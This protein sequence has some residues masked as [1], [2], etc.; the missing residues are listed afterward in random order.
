MKSIPVIIKVLA[1]FF[2]KS[3]GSRE[4]ILPFLIPLIIVS[5][6]VGIVAAIVVAMCK[7]NEKDLV[8]KLKTQ[9]NITQHNKINLWLYIYLTVYGMFLVLVLLA[10]VSG[11][12]GEMQ[13][14]TP[15]GNTAN[16]NYDYETEMQEENSA[17]GA[18]DIILMAVIFGILI[19][20]IIAI[21]NFT[22][23]LWQVIPSDIARTT[24]KKAAIFSLIPFFNWYW[25]FVA[26][27]G[28]AIDINKT[29]SRYGRQALIS[30]EFATAVCVIWV[31]DVVVSM[32]AGEFYNSLGLLPLFVMVAINFTFFI[33]LRNAT[34]ELLIMKSGLG[35][36]P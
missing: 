16:L 12:G 1:K 24:P 35:G 33:Q 26:Y 36:S 14:E 29:A 28:L 15:A 10:M 30:L 34:T 8:P 25:W 20:W 23:N 9:Y 13:G 2:G 11:V 19:M 27:K 3:E 18:V 7:A 22:A 6:V 17:N 4:A 32:F 5:I 21:Y 31:A